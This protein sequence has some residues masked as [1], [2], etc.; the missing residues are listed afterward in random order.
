MNI[1][2][3]KRFNLSQAGLVLIGGDGAPWVKEGAKNYFPNSVYQLCKFHLESK[4]K[5]TLPYHKEMQK[6]IRNLLK[7]EQIDKALKEL[8][9]ERNLRPEYKKDIEGLIHYIYYNQEG[10]NVVDRLRK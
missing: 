1:L 5:Q 10:V 2:G 7:K 3:K 9:Y 6:E 4:L 8:Q